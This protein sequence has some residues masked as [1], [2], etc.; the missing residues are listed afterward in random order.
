MSGFVRP[1]YAP[2]L[3]GLLWLASGA[4]A[5]T[6]AVNETPA[7]LLAVSGPIRWD[8]KSAMKQISGTKGCDSYTPTWATDGNL[9]TAVGDCRFKGAPQKIGMGFGRIS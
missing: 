4:V 5:C 7:E 3:T 8:P 1:G 2:V 6:D 9:Y